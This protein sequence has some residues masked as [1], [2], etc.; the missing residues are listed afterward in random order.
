MPDV[1]AIAAGDPSSPVLL[2]LHGW[3]GSRDIWKRF[4]QRYGPTRYVISVDLP[5][6]LDTRAPEA[7]KIEALAAWVLDVADRLQIDRFA[8]MGHS[9][10]GNLAAYVS[11]LAPTRVTDVILVDAA[12]YSDRL[13]VP[14]MY[15]APGYGKL[16][17]RVAR[18]ASA[19]A[20]GFSGFFT[21]DQRGG[22]WRPWLRRCIYFAHHNAHREM[23][24]QLRLMV[25]SPFD[26][27]K[28]PRE[29]GILVV[30]GQQDTVVPVELAHEL[31]SAIEK[32]R[33]GDG[34]DRG[35]LSLVVYPTANHSPMDAVP[36]EFVQDVRTF[37]DG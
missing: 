31:V 24:D 2:C 11:A 35:R 37:L 32:N 6:T 16:L 18:F 1:G 36:M 9:M 29:T 27:A 25:S 7:W 8:I 22:F 21:E 30:H 28:F 15:L 23:T 20:G 5:G 3:G 12:I 17:L 4:L 26:P 10:G 13:D 34:A 33:E 19:I 14:K